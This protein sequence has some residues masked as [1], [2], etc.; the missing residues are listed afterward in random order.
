MK[1]YRPNV[2]RQKWLYT[3]M[4]SKAAMTA[5]GGPENGSDDICEI[6]FDSPEFRLP[7]RIRSVAD[8]IWVSDQINEAYE[9]EYIAKLPKASAEQAA[10]M[11]A[12]FLTPKIAEVGL[13]H[14]NPFIRLLTH[15][16]LVRLAK[17]GVPF[18]REILAKMEK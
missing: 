7:G 8:A 17:E 6:I 1:Q 12:R 3:M 11:L 5:P 14:S 18:A 16:Q 15:D 9:R 10:F 2:D 4:K 13:N